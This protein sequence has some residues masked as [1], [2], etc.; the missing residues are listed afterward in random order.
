MDRYNEIFKYVQE[1]LKGDDNKATKLDERFPFRIR[2]EHIWRVFIW[3]NRLIDEENLSTINKNALLIASLFHDI[4]YALSPHS[5]SHAE[6][7]EIIFREYCKNNFIEKE[8]EDFIAYLIKNH[9]NKNLMEFENT[10]IELILLME[11]DIL[12]ETGAMSIVWDCM[13]EGMNEE[14][15][16]S[17]AYDHILQKTC[18]IINSNP[19]KTKTAKEYWK[20]K[21][22]L[23]K[24]FIKEYAFDLD[25]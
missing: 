10:P 24:N 14:Q 23:V 9:S 17:K 13:A 3:A 25:V 18:K 8:E 11:A 4:G 22:E 1:L 19:M 21:Q 20:I 12:D 15:S 7:S 16:Y 6:N 2:S 5:K